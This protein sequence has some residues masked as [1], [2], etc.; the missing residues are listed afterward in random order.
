VSQI[1]HCPM[2]KIAILM[3]LG[4]LPICQRQVKGFNCEQ[5]RAFKIT[6]TCKKSQAQ[7][8]KSYAAY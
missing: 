4:N 7:G 6:T 2:K 8:G 3:Q 1:K 5:F